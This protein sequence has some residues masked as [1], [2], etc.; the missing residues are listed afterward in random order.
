M[1]R[2]RYQD[3]FDD[4]LYDRYDDLAGEYEPGELADGFSVIA[5]FDD[6]D[7]EEFDD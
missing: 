3:K 5:A 6:P 4:P 2:P 1:P 7:E